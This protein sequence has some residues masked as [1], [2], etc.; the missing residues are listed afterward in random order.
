MNA[1]LS[2]LYRDG[3]PFFRDPKNPGDFFEFNRKISERFRFFFRFL[4]SGNFSVYK[5]CFLVSGFSASVKN[6]RS[7]SG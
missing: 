3:H 1:F 7:D 2:G 5:L 6:F 4:F